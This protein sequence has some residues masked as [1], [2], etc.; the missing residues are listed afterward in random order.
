MRKHYRA[1]FKA[2]AVKE[3]LKEEKTISQLAAQLGVGY[4]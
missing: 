4:P 3:L 2:D 1:T